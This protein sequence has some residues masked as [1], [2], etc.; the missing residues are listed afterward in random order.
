MF[1]ATLYIL[2]CHIL[3]I[4]PISVI[5]HPEDVTVVKGDPATLICRVDTG[6][7]RWFKDGVEMKIEE[8]EEIFL[9]P[10]GSLFFLSASIGD[11]ALY[12]CGIEADDT[13]VVMSD[14]AALIVSYVSGGALPEMVAT[15]EESD[16]T[17]NDDVKSIHVEILQ[18]EKIIPAAVYIISMVIVGVMTVLIIAGATII[19]TKIKQMQHHPET[20]NTELERTV[21]YNSTK[22]VSADSSLRN[23][24]KIPIFELY[25]DS[26]HQYD[27][28]V[29][30]TSR[31]LFNTSINT[32]YQKLEPIYLIPH[33]NYSYC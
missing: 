11:T 3:S 23:M 21:L 32:K 2:C 8:D 12:N 6:D 18:E 4:T 28:P 15:I 10:D 17:S 25:S 7:V 29:I 24:S 16:A 26:L 31:K 1:L 9:L 13:E 22:L 20:G 27:V 30:S 14:P 5:E 33:G 19:F